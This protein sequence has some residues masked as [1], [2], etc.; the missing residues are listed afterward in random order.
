[1]TR[2]H[3]RVVLGRDLADEAPWTRQPQL[4]TPDDAL[5][6][7]SRGSPW[8]VHWCGAPSASSAD[9]NATRHL[10]QVREYRR[11]VGPAEQE[12]MVAKA[13]RKGRTRTVMLAEL[14][15]SATGSEVVVFIEGGLR[16]WGGRC[17]PF[18][19]G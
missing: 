12:R 16:P 4:L 9:D 10:A 13:E 8:V 14:W 6:R 3:P 15:L 18:T 19:S 5:S 7:V 1:M 11:F 2:K 17:D